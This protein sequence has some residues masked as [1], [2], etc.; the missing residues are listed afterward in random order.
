MVGFPTFVKPSFRFQLR[1]QNHDKIKTDSGEVS[2][3][4]I[5]R[6]CPWIKASKSS[7]VQLPSRSQMNFGGA[8]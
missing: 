8:P 3:A 1:K 5:S 4:E 6:S 7:R 2:N